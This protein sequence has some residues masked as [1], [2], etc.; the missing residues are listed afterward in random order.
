M[1]GGSDGST[2]GDT[3]Y[4]G[5]DNGPGQRSGI[6]ALEDIDQIS[7]VAAPGI[8]SQSVQNA[9]ISHCENLMDRFAIL[10]PAYTRAAPLTDVERQ[11]KLYDTK[12]A[13]LYFP[14][15]LVDDPVTDVDIWV[16]PSGHMAG[17]Y[18]RTDIERGVHK[19]PANAVPR[20]I[21]GLDLTVTRREQEILNPEKI[22]I[23]RDF[24]ADNRGYR[25]WG[26]RCLTSETPW[27]YI[28]VRRL[29]IYLE[30]S[31]DEGTQFVVFEPN[32]E[33]LWT[34]V[35]QTVSIFLTRVWRDGALFGST[36]EEAFFVRCDET[37]M[38]PDDILNGRLIMEIGVAPVRPA[39]FVVIRI[40]QFPG[41]TAIEEL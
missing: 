21:T 18:A 32:D 10:D 36:P 5:Q 38:S 11:R 14:R 20:S 24:R 40:G 12:Y 31:L 37:T 15:L 41:G 39:E 28:N 27:I 2:P 34:R 7:I 33:K 29:F 6:R 30:E 1:A 13:A 19:A 3:D 16:P 4:V 17:I 9:L 23:I 26:A 35:R 8:T 25:V 22:N